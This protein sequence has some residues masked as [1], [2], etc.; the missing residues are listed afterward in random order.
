[1]ME[2]Y[3]DGKKEKYWKVEERQKKREVE[4]ERTFVKPKES[5]QQTNKQKT[6]E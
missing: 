2:G 5:E 4:E 1:M 6:D 3:E